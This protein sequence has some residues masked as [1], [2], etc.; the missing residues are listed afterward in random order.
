[1][2]ILAQ[3]MV[4]RIFA[5]FSLKMERTIFKKKRAFLALIFVFL[6]VFSLIWAVLTYQKTINRISVLP[7]QSA[8]VYVESQA[9]D[10][11]PATVY[12]L[13]QLLALDEAVMTNLIQVC[14]QAG[15]MHWGLISAGLSPVCFAQDPANEVVT[16][17]H[18]QMVELDGHRFLLISEGEVALPEITS[19][20]WQDRWAR[21]RFAQV[22]EKQAVSLALRE[23]TAWILGG[24]SESEAMVALR[25]STKPGLLRTPLESASM[26]NGSLYMQTTA[27]Q[28]QASAIPAGPFAKLPAEWFDYPSQLHILRGNV[29]RMVQNPYDSGISWR[30][31]STL[32][33]QEAQVLLEAH[34][35]QLSE[36]YPFLADRTLPDGTV[37]S[38]LQLSRDQF[39]LPDQSLLLSEQPQ[40]ALT[41]PGGQLTYAY[42]D[43]LFSIQQGASSQLRASE[44][45]SETDSV[46]VSCLVPGATVSGYAD[47]SSADDFLWRRVE[48]SLDSR[49][50]SLCILPEYTSYTQLNNG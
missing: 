9:S 19:P 44:S 14:Q 43:G 30:L 31:E 37:I 8:R 7:W 29:Q 22:T 39:L 32:P 50:L 13:A 46:S 20:T 12:I 49:Q 48:F 38:E 33:L 28:A 1:M 23:E 2:P 5:R 6:A 18:Q 40:G 17:L 3:S 15:G 36:T 34:L 16:D 42:K 4:L 21:F 10:L 41:Y 26:P 45:D 27:T 35:N 25:L 24:I 11:H 47:A